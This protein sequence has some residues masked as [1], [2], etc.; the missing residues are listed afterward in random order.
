ME[1]WVRGAWR[2]NGWSACMAEPSAAHLKLS[3]RCSSSVLQ[4]KIKSLKDAHVQGE[5]THLPI[6][7]VHFIDEYESRFWNHTLQDSTDV[8]IS[9]CVVHIHHRQTTVC[10]EVNEGDY[11]WGRIVGYII[12]FFLYVLILLLVLYNECYILLKHKSVRKHIV[13]LS[14]ILSYLICSC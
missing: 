8:K 3:Q 2:E 6:K 12:L 7:G 13:I 10:Q 4:Y 9:V 1:A 11:L 14:L 5:L